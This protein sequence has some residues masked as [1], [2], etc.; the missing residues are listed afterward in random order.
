MPLQ[1]IDPKIV[2]ALRNGH[3][4]P[5]KDC[6]GMVSILIPYIKEDEQYLQRTINSAKKNAA[7]KIEI[8]TEFD[9]KEEGHRILTNRMAEKAK[10]K[11]LFRL[12]AHCALSPQWD[13]RMKESCKKNTLV[14]P[15]VDKL[16]D[17]DWSFAGNDGGIILLD[18]R[19]RNYYLTPWIPFLERP[20]E[21]ET[22]S[23]QAFAFMIRRK[24]FFDGDCL[25]ESLPPWGA[26]ALEISLK[27]WLTGGRVLIR[28]DVEC[29]HLFRKNNLTPFKVDVKKKDDAYVRIGRLWRANRGK[30]QTRPL[31]WLTGKFADRILKPE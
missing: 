23:I 29:A 16:N 14:V 10:G 3:R 7:G 31:E 21:V 9:E 17:K 20:L 30:G 22:M 1:V 12:D 2:Q 15:I 18:R 6:G 19:M 8:L 11:F 28:T 27:T 4:K 26:A 25:D 5:I 13:L 24:D